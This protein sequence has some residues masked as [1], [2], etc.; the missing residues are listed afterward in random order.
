MV[1]PAAHFIS[2]GLHWLGMLKE[3][4]G[5][6]LMKSIA[7]QGKE[8]PSLFYFKLFVGS[9]LPFVSL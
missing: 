6:K 2:P 4:A 3:A 7:T 5:F 9:F 8:T 1:A